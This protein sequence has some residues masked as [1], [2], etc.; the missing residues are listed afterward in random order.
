MCRTLGKMV[1]ADIHIRSGNQ[2]PKI[3][4]KEEAGNDPQAGKIHF[5]LFIDGKKQIIKHQF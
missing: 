3:D 2:A 5:S 4:F 1:T